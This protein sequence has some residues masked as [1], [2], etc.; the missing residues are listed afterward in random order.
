MAIYGIIMAI[1]LIGKMKLPPEGWETDT[2]THVRC[3]FCGYAVFCTG[4]TVGF[5]NL[6]CG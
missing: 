5:S 2:A 4:L 3:L 1:I 6:F